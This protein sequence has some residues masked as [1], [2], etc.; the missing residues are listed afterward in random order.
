MDLTFFVLFPCAFLPSHTKKHIRIFLVLE[1][2]HLRKKLIESGR[3]RSVEDDN[4]KTFYMCSVVF[5]DCQ[6]RRDAMSTIMGK[7]VLGIIIMLI[8]K[9]LIIEPITQ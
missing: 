6:M 5:V 2:V 3:G 7:F 8:C 1:R 4:H 9:A